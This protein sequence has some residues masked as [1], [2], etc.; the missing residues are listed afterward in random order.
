MGKTAE[1]RDRFEMVASANQLT[2]R[3]SIAGLQ[4][5]VSLDTNV[6]WYPEA[7]L[8]IIGTLFPKNGRGAITHIDEGTAAAIC[9]SGGAALLDAFWG[10]YVAFGAGGASSHFILRDPT[11]TCPCLW[12]ADDRGSFFAADARMLLALT[13]IKGSIDL[14][15]VVHGL[16]YRDL[17]GTR[18]CLVGVNELLPGSALDLP[19]DRTPAIRSAWSPW[20]FVYRGGKALDRQEAV[21]RVREQVMRCTGE[22][23]SVFGNILLE[24]SGGVDSSVVASALSS[25]SGVSALT[26]ASQ[27]PEGDER[28]Y[29]RAAAA[30]AGIEL[31]EAM[32]DPRAIDIGRSA[33][34]QLPRPST[35]LFAQHAEVLAIARAGECKAEAF[36]GGGGGDNVF[37]HL[38]SAAPAADRL[39][40]GDWL[41][42]WATMRDIVA[43]NRSDIRTVARR[44]FTIARRKG[45]RQ[46]WPADFRL[47][48]DPTCAFTSDNPWLIAPANA[49]AGARS[50]VSALTHVHNHLEGHARS[51]HG[52]V[53]YPLLSQPLIELCLSIPSWMW[54]EGGIDRS[55]VRDAFIDKLSPRTATRRTKGAMDG[56]VSEIFETQRTAIR[57][58]LLGGHL[59]QA[60][61]IDIAAVTSLLS[62]GAVF[63][64][65]RLLSLV[66]VEAWISAWRS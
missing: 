17:R 9:A 30:A 34:W 29:A 63:Q 65:Y 43:A 41:G 8:A 13:D 36:F 35:R 14:E 59:A 48:A 47:L 61:I 46:I 38:Q 24:L 56:F 21:D 31:H 66:D 52:P 40:L 55:I 15:Q 62:E 1:A 26:F 25:C 27:H 64:D 18:T 28:T 53:V 3:I 7:G 32:L 60:G 45:P 49:L 42:A 6:I 2:K 10:G 39:K 58:M 57:D 12:R 37:A 51:G 33:A 23:R 22:W 4:V 16:V 50:H 19:G 5:A 11:G 54:L 44:A 20:S